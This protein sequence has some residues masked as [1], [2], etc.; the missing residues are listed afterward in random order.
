MLYRFPELVHNVPSRLGVTT[1]MAWFLYDIPERWK[2]EVWMT[3]YDTVHLLIG[4]RDY[5]D[6][7]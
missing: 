3:D 2:P 7:K 4:H 6:P 1:N 5:M